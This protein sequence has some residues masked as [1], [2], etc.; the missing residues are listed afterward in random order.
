MGIAGLVTPTHQRHKLKR[1]ISAIF[2]QTR[3][4]RPRIV[5][6]ARFSTSGIMRALALT[7]CAAVAPATASK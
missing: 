2:C 1:Q 6:H 4:L 5:D 3:P 7:G